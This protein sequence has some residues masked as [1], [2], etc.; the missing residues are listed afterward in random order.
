MQHDR[1]A[2]Y[3]KMW[4]KQTIDHYNRYCDIPDLADEIRDDGFYIPAVKAV[5][6]NMA[7][8]YLDKFSLV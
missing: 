4:F 8:K 7:D 6:W 3:A 2:E 5:K 1:A